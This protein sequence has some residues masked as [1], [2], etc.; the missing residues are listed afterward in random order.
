MLDEFGFVYCL[1]LRLRNGFVGYA[2]LVC[3]WFHL[4]GGDLF[5]FLYLGCG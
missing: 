2:G 1:D 3:V 4:L 5:C